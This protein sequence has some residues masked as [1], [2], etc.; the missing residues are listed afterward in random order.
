MIE[1]AKNYLSD[2]GGIGIH[3]SLKNCFIEGSN[4]FNPTIL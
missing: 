3:D 2:C 4:P 1:F